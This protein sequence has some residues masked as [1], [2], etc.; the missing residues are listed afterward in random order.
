MVWDLCIS[1]SKIDQLSALVAIKF[2]KSLAEF[3]MIYLVVPW[4]GY[5]LDAV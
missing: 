2:R 1:S 4:R 3:S 5:E